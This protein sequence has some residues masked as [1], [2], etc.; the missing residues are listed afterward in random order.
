MEVQVRYRKILEWLKTESFHTAELV[1]HQCLQC[2]TFLV[3]HL[4]LW[5]WLVV[6]TNRK[7]F[8]QVK[9]ILWLK[10]KCFFVHLALFF[11]FFSGFSTH[12]IKNLSGKISFCNIWFE[13]LSNFMDLSIWKFFIVG[14]DLKE[15]CQRTEFEVFQFVDFLRRTY[16]EISA[17]PFPV[18]A[19]IDG[20]GLGGGLK[21]VMAW[22]IPIA[23]PQSKLGV[24]E[25][26]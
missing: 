21:M 11:V 9:N 1:F 19:A 2:N 4:H 3:H 23:S 6:N 17:L 22:D 26:N 14:A 5:E 20:C 18:L 15:R 8:K 13:F 25:T 12:V 7:N 16:N 10:V 24:V